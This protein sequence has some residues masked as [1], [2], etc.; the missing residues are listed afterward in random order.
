[1]LGWIHTLR[2]AW[3]GK[4]G[5]SDERSM[6]LSSHSEGENIRTVFTKCRHS[7]VIHLLLTSSDFNCLIEPITGSKWPH[8]V[9]EMVWSACQCYVWVSVLWVCI[10]MCAKCVCLCL[11]ARTSRE[12]T[13]ADSDSL[14]LWLHGTDAA[15]ALPSVSL[16]VWKTKRPCGSNGFLM[17]GMQIVN[18]RHQKWSVTGSKPA[19]LS[20]GITKHHDQLN[21]IHFCF[22][23][24]SSKSEILG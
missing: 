8:K 15:C 2:G 19:I 10:C 21:G 16:V 7:D 1:M 11:C 4:S 22:T 14:L 13:C 17:V 23:N 9:M 3:G 24:R 12:R 5:E 18:Y 20:A 6:G